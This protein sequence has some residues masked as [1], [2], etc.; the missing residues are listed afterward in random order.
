[1]GK[2]PFD[3][4]CSDLTGHCLLAISSVLEKYSGE[5][6]KNEKTMLSGMFRK[7]LNYLEANQESDGSWNPLWFGTQYTEGFR[8][9]VY[10]TAK[11]TTYLKDS[12]RHTHQNLKNKNRL[13]ALIEKG[14]NFL[15]H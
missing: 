5:L 10:G 1:M 7:S 4:S 13:N 15:I 8:N 9:P 3:R 12:I 14:I 6:T 11:V 2:L